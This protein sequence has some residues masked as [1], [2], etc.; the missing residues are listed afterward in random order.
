MDLQEFNTLL[1]AD[2]P[3]EDLSLPLQA[4]WHDAK[5]NWDHAH[6]LAQSA[7]DKAGAWVHAYLH[8]KEGDTSNAAYWYSRA[9]RTMSPLPLNA[10]REEI[11]QALLQ[12]PT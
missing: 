11:A 12:E 7:G 6:Y 2:S 9:G 10:E 3:P 8:R 1:A 4:L 5:G